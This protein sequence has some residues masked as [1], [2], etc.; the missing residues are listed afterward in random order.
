MP[1]S[2]LRI[3]EETVHSCEMGLFYR[4]SRGARLYNAMEG[5]EVH[6]SDLTVKRTIVRSQ[7]IMEVGVNAYDL[8]HEMIGRCKENGY[9]GMIGLKMTQSAGFSGAAGSIIYATA[10]KFQ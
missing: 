7:F 2:F 4:K 3:L 5:F 6:T 10:V 9:N 1:L 8:L